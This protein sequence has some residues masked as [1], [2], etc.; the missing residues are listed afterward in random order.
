MG[1]LVCTHGNTYKS[2]LQ[3]TGGDGIII[4]HSRHNSQHTWEGGGPIRPFNGQKNH[5]FE[6]D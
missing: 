1:L 4:Y 2:W 3:F 5:H 6:N